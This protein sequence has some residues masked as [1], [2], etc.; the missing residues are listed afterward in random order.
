ML[1]AMYG[2]LHAALL[3]YLKL[4]GD[5]EEFGFKM[6]KYDSCVANKIVNGKQ[7]T[8]TWHV[9]DLKALHEEE[10]ELM[11]L[12]IFLAKKYEDKITVK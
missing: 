10:I 8:V 4:Q 2:L 5:L 3:F 7:M 11:K 6:N 1:K 12:V 9:D